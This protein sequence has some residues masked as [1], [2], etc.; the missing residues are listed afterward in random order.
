MTVLRA[1]L[2]LE[3]PARVAVDERAGLYAGNQADNFLSASL[4]CHPG[5]LRDDLADRV[6]VGGDGEVLV[7]KHFAHVEPIDGRKR[8]GQRRL[9]HLESDE[10]MIGLRRIRTCRDLHHVER[11]FDDDVLCPG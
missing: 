6:A 9:R 10:T 7:A 4:P 11:E 1:E 5:E 3:L 2:L 8:A